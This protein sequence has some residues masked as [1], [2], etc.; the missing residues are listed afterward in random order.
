[1]GI[2]DKIKEKIWYPFFTNKKKGTGMG[3][4]IIRKIVNSLNGD[5][6]LVESGSRGSTFKITFYN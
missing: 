3:L 6:S 5:I 1:K 2:D 4:A